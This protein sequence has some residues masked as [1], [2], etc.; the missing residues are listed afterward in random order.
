MSVYLYIC[1]YD[2]I[3]INNTLHYKVRTMYNNA[4]RV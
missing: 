1:D 4:P 3:I 2:K